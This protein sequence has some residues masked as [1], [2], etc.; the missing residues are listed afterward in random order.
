MRCN[1]NYSNKMTR[2]SSLVCCAMY[3]DKDTHLHSHTTD[4]SDQFCPFSPLEY[5]GSGVGV[6]DGL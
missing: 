1:R 6:S 3:T 2:C 4:C 5:G